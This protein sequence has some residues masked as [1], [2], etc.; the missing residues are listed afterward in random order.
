MLDNMNKIKKKTHYIILLIIF[1]FSNSY[2]FCQ[3]KQIT[4]YVCDSLSQPIPDAIVEIN[5][6]LWGSNLLNGVTDKKG[7]VNF[8]L[9]F[10]KYEIILSHL[11]YNQRNEMII[12]NQNHRK[13]T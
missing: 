5:H 9:P 7:M 4:V 13:E 1:L 8:Q 12:V 3:E 2:L 11:K 6:W 10:G